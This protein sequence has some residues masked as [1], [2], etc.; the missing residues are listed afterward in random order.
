MKDEES[1]E[2]VRERDSNQIMG[3]FRYPVELGNPSGTEFELV[4]PMVDTSATYSF[5]PASLLERLEVEPLREMIF[6][7]AGG[8][9]IKRSLG[10]ARV[11]VV[12]R[13][14][15]TIVVF[16]DEDAL[17][18]LGAHALEGLG[19]A[20]DPFHRRLIELEEAYLL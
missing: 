13:E 14:A 9:R 1:D 2:R 4:N 12:G 6:V 15:T 16:G 3:T 20:V 17:P 10:E 18:L 19:L 5:M 7:I 8:G 11:R